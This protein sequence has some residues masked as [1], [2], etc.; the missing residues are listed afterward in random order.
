MNK[1][2]LVHASQV[3]HLPTT[4]YDDTHTKGREFIAFDCEYVIFALISI[5][6]ILE[7]SNSVLSQK[8][9]LGYQLE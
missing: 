3:M 9:V 5:S 7:T 1:M 2:E 6:A 4:T 8:V